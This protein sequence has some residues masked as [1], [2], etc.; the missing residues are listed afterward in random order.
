M[1]DQD[2]HCFDSSVENLCAEKDFYQFSLDIEDEITGEQLD[3]DKAIF[4]D[5]DSQIAPVIKEIIIN[6]DIETLNLDQILLIHKYVVYQY[7]RSP[8]IKNIAE[9]VSGN[10]KAGRQIQ[11]L[12]FLD[13]RFIN[14]VVDAIGKLNLQITKASEG[15]EFIISDSPVLWSPTAEGIYF[16][17]SPELCL[18]YYKSNATPLDSICISYLEFLTSNRFNIAQSKDVLDRFWKSDKEDILMKC[19]D[20]CDSYWK[21][22][23]ATKNHIKCLNKFK[24]N[25]Y[26]PF[27]SILQKP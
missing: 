5:L 19:C 21:C 3:Y 24:S 10:K 23:I 1:K 18:H 14:D 7:F 13:T 9:R 8:A 20:P 2:G 22:I 11:G 16:P 12:N 17:I 4:N 25:V 26:K 27:I 15:S 6:H